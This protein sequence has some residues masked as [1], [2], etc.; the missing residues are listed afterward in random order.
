MKDENQTKKLFFTNLFLWLVLLIT[1]PLVKLFT[2]PTEQVTSTELQSFVLLY[3]IL[4]II[5]GFVFI[6]DIKKTILYLTESKSL[7]L[8]ESLYFTILKFINGLI[9]I[10][11]NFL[12]LIFGSVGVLIPIV[13]I[14]V[15][16]GGIIGILVFGWKQL[17]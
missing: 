4:T 2:E 11:I 7:N 15:I 8:Y 17:I 14:V 5:Y 3:L 10:I 12:G 13:I 9:E 1:L 6:E 16:L